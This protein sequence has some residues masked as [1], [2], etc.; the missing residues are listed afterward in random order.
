MVQELVSTLEKEKASLQS[1]TEASWANI[2]TK[3]TELARLNADLSSKQEQMDEALCRVAE[4]DSK[5]KTLLTVALQAARNAPHPLQCRELEA[6]LH[7]VQAYSSTLQQY[8]TT[9]Q[10]EVNVAKEHSQELQ[11]QRD[12]LQ[13]QLA[14]AEG[15]EASLKS[16]LN[17]EKVTAGRRTTSTC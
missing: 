9:L 11:L 1:E 7:Q 4:K 8:N 17:V 16:L 5:V 6:V 3:D 15:T 14:S 10:A 12:A 2:A 13:K